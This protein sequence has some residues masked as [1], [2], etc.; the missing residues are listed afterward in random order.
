MEQEQKP[1]KANKEGWIVPRRERF[2]YYIGSGSHFTMH[3]FMS[4]FLVTYLLMIGVDPIASAAVLVVL[5]AWDAVNDT[6]FGYVI[7]RVQFKQGGG[8]FSRWFFSGR[9]LPW[10]RIATFVI[11]F[12]MII[13]FT[14][15][16]SA[17]M[18]MR[19]LQYGIG[20]L[21]YDTSYTISFAPWGCM[22]TSMTNNVDERNHLQSYSILGQALGLMPVLFLGTFLIAGAFGY[23]ST[24]IL[25][26][27]YGFLLA[28]PALFSIKERNVSES[29][30]VP[31]GRYSL[32]EMTRF[33]KKSKEFLFFEFAQIMWGVLATGGAFGLFVAYYLFG[34]AYIAVLFALFTF[35]P[36]IFLL[37]FFPIIFKRVNKISALQIA[38]FLNLAAGLSMYFIRPEGLMA[39]PILFYCLLIVH[40]TAT[41]FVAI[42]SALLLPDLAEIAK[43]RTKTDHVGIIWS[44]HSTVTKLVSSLVASLGI[45]ILAAYGW[46]SV[47]AGSF[48]EL[49]ELNAIGIGLQTPQ[50]LQ[51]LWDVTFLFPSI[52]FGL[53]ALAF[54]LVK[55]DRHSIETMIRVNNGEITHE[56]AE[57]LLEQGAR[58]SSSSEIDREGEGTQTNERTI[59]DDQPNER[60]NDGM[61]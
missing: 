55:V 3:T 29:P 31:E 23:T 26:A 15:N 59:D 10:F 47:T 13:T 53:A 43:Y 27:I 28:I 11:P 22:L 58:D 33:L 38:C 9:Y 54:L 5:R 7:D 44:I 12:S 21:L 19:I 18:W 34:D 16:T 51:G 60:E 1:A 48:E 52:G 36:T 39:V 30:E 41:V 8:R 46:V 57:K 42:G 24:A 6:V 2:S 49:A 40:G 61:T 25:F 56:E 17:P 50:A 4:A 35:L 20:Y 32:R 37:P 14:V 45:V